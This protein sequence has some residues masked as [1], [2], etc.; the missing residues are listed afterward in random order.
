M[1]H[2]VFVLAA[3]AA[4]CFQSCK[5]IKGDGPVVSE[6]RNVKN[7]RAISSDID[8]DVHF[9]PGNIYEVEIRAQQNIIDILETRV[10]GGELRLRYNGN[11]NIGRH[12]RI[13]IYITG[14]SPEGFTV[15]GSG[16]VDVIHPLQVTEMKLRITGSGS[17]NINDLTAE[18]INA[19]ISGSGDINV[20]GGTARSAAYQV[21]GSGRM[22]LLDVPVKDVTTTTRGS[23]NI[24][25]HAVDNLDVTIAGSGDV[26]YKGSPRIN[27]TI[28]GSGNVRRW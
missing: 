12:D 25:L 23:G 15:A 20:N 11:Y 21:D 10:S 4:L 5:K 1:K 3:M 24:R 18:H 19:Q 13:D 26:I 28:L 17:I 9:T 22:D 2:F 16:N 6:F 7:F 27:K 14:P 8:G